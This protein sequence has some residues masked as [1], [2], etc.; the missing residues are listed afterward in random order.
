MLITMGQQRQGKRCRAGKEVKQGRTS[1]G[2]AG[3]GR[4]GYI[5]TST[6]G[7]GTST[8]QEY[9]CRTRQGRAWQVLGKAKCC[10]S[11]T[12]NTSEA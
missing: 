5:G 1:E 9:Y 4:E 11:F 2:R 6:P 7:T 3:Q 10:L 12:S 8:A